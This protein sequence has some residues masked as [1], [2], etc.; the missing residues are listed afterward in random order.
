VTLRFAPNLSLLW[1][2][3]PFAERFERA[4]RAGFT[5][6]ELWWPGEEAAKQ[7]PDLVAS[8]GLELALLNFDAGDMAAGD[9]GLASDPEQAQRLR[10]HV[11]QA[12]DIARACGCQRLNLL[13]GLRQEQYSLAEQ[14]ECARENLAWTADQAAP[15]G[16][17]VLVEAVNSFEN[18]QYLVTTTP[19]AAQL[20]GEVDRPNVRMQYDCYHMQRMEGNLTAT[21]DAHWALI[22]HIQIAD[23]PARHEPGTGEINYR[24]VLDHIDRHGYRGYVG[25]EYR[26]STASVEES[27][28]WLEWL[29]R[30]R[31]REASPSDRT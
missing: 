8:W 25:L 10:A 31:G 15:A 30:P 20:I 19:A 13:V 22:D 21:L 17:T 16:V 26:P 27:F 3:L 28:A 18:G 23:S 1:A 7:I 12:L 24:Y 6:V 11:P 9:R 5:A 4:A 2:Q 14:L 29:G